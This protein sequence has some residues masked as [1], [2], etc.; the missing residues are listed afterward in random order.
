MWCTNCRGNLSML[1]TI[2]FGANKCS[3][4][5]HLSKYCAECGGSTQCCETTIGD[6]PEIGKCAVCVCKTKPIYSQTII[7]HACKR[8]D[9]C[10]GC[11]T[12]WTEMK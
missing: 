5:D 11:T 6:K 12:K 4:P 9:S 8:G 10:K 1:V 2:L 3:H 7:C